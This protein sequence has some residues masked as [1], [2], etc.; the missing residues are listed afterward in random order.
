VALLR[1]ANYDFAAIRATLDELEAGRPQRA[2]AAVEQRRGE[3]ARAS[4]RC[5]EAIA[6]L[7]AYVREFVEAI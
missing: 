6:A 2:V 5:V 7:H 3:L 1:Q 4:W